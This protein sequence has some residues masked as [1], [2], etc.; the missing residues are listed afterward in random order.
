MYRR[1]EPSVGVQDVVEALRTAPGARATPS[2][3][4]DGVDRWKVLAETIP[5][6]VWTADPD[7]A[8]DYYNA[9]WF[10]YTGLTLEGTRGWG[11]GPV[12]HPDDVEAC[13]E[14]W[15]RAVRTG[16]TCEVECRFR[17]AAD[18]A[19]RWH[20]G[21]ALPVRDADG[22][23][24]KWFG[25]CTDIHE[26]RQAQEALSA[27]R[28]ALERRVQERT[29]DLERALAE[30]EA[31]LRQLAA[32]RDEAVAVSRFRAAVVETIDSLVVVIDRAGRIVAF[33]RACEAV[34]GFR[35]SEVVGRLLWDALIPPDERDRVQAGFLR[36]CAGDFPNRFENAWITKDGGRRL[37]SW[38]NTALVDDEGTP[39]HVIGT[40]IDVTA[41]R[42][43]EAERRQVEGALRDKTRLLE[44][45]LSSMGD[46][47]SVV[48]EAGRFLMANDAARRLVGFG[49]TDAPPSEWPSYFGAFRADGVTAFPT[50]EM[51]LLRAIRG[52]STDD[53]EMFVR[54]A[55]VPEGRLVSISGRPLRDDTGALRGGLV[56]FRDMTEAR[57]VARELE[58]AKELA[59]SAT[60]AKSEF[61]ANMSH[62][63]RTP[64]G[65]VLGMARLLLG[66]TLTP[67]QR[68]Y[69]RILVSSGEGLLRIIND[70]LDLSKVEAGKLDV[71]RVEFDLHH[72]VEDAVSVARGTARERAGEPPALPRFTM[73]FTIDPRLPRR[74]VGDPNRLRQVLL[75]LLGNAAKFTHEGEVALRVSPAAGGA[76]PGQV[77]FEVRDTGIGIPPE[78]QRR[79]FAPF[80][81]A[82]ASTTRQFGGT[83]LGLAI[84]KQLV[85]LLGGEIGFESRPGHGSTF[86]FTA[87]FEPAGAERGRAGEAAP[88]VRAPR[89]APARILLVEDNRVNQILM[90]QMLRNLGYEAA[91]EP[92]GAQALARLEREAFD[93]VLM[94]CQM[95]V[96]DGYTAT[97]ALRRW[98]EATGRARTPVLAMTASA[99]SD[100]RA[101]CLAAGMDEHL[102]KPV[103]VEELARAIARHV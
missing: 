60:R 23:I 5:Q 79:L 40:G 101:R 29:A 81:Q 19:Y 63:L 28:A 4:P 56:V 14:R 37:I 90:R 38:S 31:L 15:S 78:V 62:E 98:E 72:A 35:A 83:G 25:T 2:A 96:M 20:L 75:N 58:R 102:A 82:D 8:T 59:E 55:Q 3:S 43:A 1:R 74:L 21:R 30:K 47:V 18:G 65:G 16:Q 99:M 54:N 24:V 86:W 95:P 66:T 100:D 80:T 12:L 103:D 48:D 41:Q 33:N 87:P 91:L 6:I 92:D 67:E 50:D 94:D 10:A 73:A 57:R 32:A 39:R 13:V 70:I 68:E 77:R 93:L 36:L 85:S 51:P 44:A 9:R 27:S 64:L 7:G 17:R 88:H 84:S 71:E 42:Q 89:T 34:T 69:A 11:F 52:E 49:T 46:G 76:R 22:R 26:Q 61:L 53:V 45:V 97:V